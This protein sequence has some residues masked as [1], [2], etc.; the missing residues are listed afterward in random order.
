MSGT[1]VIIGGHED[2]EGEKV[3]L[4]EVARR[5]DRRR[6]VVI[7]AASE[8]PEELFAEYRKAFADLGL[9][10]VIPLDVRTREEALDEKFS[11]PLRGAGSVFFTGGDQL[12]LTSQLGGTPLLDAVKA[13]YS[14]GGVIAGTSAGASV[15]SDTM[16]VSGEGE[17]S[18]KLGDSLRLAPGFGF[19][20]GVI[21]DQHFAE[22]G[23][24]GRLLAAVAQNPASLGLGIDED[25]AIVV[26]RSRF[27]VVGRG[28]VYVFDASTA[29]FSNVAEAEADETLSVHD[30]ALHALRA[31]DRFDLKPRRPFRSTAEEE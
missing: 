14:D 12:R 23:R 11:E 1:L 16:M 18:P 28:G 26:E 22:R 4:R 15:Q 25:T 27:R 24:M 20:P 29:T 17:S 31:G 6:L 9:K 10:D 8:E 21:I 13:I 19:L 7:G 2:R 30:V 5:T 3:I